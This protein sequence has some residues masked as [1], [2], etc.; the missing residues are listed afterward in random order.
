MSAEDVKS[1]YKKSKKKSVK[2]VQSECSRTFFSS[3]LTNQIAGK[4]SIRLQEYSINSIKVCLFCVVAEIMKTDNVLRQG[5]EYF[6]RSHWWK[7]IRDVIVVFKNCVF[8]FLDAVFLSRDK[9]LLAMFF[10]FSRD[11]VRH[12]SRL[13]MLKAFQLIKQGASIKQ[14]SLFCSCPVLFVKKRDCVLFQRILPP[15][16]HTSTSQTRARSVPCINQLESEE[17]SIQKD[18]RVSSHRML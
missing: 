15:Q 18:F 11:Q 3:V 14:M 9:V 13:E 8:F 5:I 16:S 17:A 7:I 2:P 6:P 4:K 10:V 1:Y 12:V